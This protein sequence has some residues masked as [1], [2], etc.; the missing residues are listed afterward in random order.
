MTAA[1]Y[2][3]QTSAPK[4]GN[5][6]SAQKTVVQG[7]TFDSKREAQRWAQLRLLEKAGEI[8]EIKLQVPIMLV[9]Q[10]GPLLSR[11]GRQMRLT[12]K[13]NKAGLTVYEDAKGTPTRDYEVRKAVAEAMGYEIIEV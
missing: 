12:D 5:K 11:T 8:S 10:K 4:G 7:I 2:Q 6:Y 13:N 9:G 3:E 1:E